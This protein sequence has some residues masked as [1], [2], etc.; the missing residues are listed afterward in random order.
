[1][2]NTL[3]AVMAGTQKAAKAED[4]ADPFEELSLDMDASLDN[5]QYPKKEFDEAREAAGHVSLCAQFATQEIWDQYKDTV[6][7]GPAKWT[8]AHAINAG[9]RCR[10]LFVGCHAGD[11]SSYDDFK[12]FFSPVIHAYHKGFDIEN[13]KHITDMDAAKISIT[14]TDAT[15]AK[16]ISTRVC[17]ARNLAQFTLNPASDEDTRLAICDLMDRVYAKIDPSSDFAGVMFRHTT[18]SDEERERL[19]EAGLLFRSRKNQAMIL[20]GDKDWGNS[21]QY[22]WRGHERQRQGEQKDQAQH[23]L[24]PDDTIAN[25]HSEEHPVAV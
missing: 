6:S 24:G 7:S 17:V 19:L 1:M 12:D 22:C 23:P 18:M 21:G 20:F 25:L 15:K 9:V 8:L 13:D 10:S 4:E 3:C 11:S 2:L 14:L 16:I 5:N